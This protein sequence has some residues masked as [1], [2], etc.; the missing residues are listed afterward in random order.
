[1]C[2]WQKRPS[3]YYIS[4]LDLAAHALTCGGKKAYWKQK[5]VYWFSLRTQVPT[6]PL[7]PL[8]SPSLSSF[9]QAVV[10]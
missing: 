6:V 4:R 9:L 7:T 3:R 2:G 8:T 1:M 10:T 5:Q